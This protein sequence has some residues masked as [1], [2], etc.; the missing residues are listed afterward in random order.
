M[1]DFMQ[2]LRS[3]GDD[4]GGPNAFSQSDRQALP[5]PLDRLLARQQR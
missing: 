5:N 4:T 3:K 2:T 1:R